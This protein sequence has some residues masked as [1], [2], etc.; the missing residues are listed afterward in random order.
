MRGDEDS[1][2]P[3]AL[4]LG[5]AVVNLV[6]CFL[7]RDQFTVPY[8][9]AAGLTLVYAGIGVWIWSAA[10]LRTA[11]SGLV[12]P[13]GDRL[14]TSGPYRF[15]RHPVYLG[16]TVAM[17]GVG[18]ATASGFGLAVTLLAF[19]PVELYRARLEDRALRRRFGDAW[20]AYARVVPAFLPWRRR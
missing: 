13:P 3:A 17:F 19:L 18:I 6:A 20:S 8:P 7:F 15:V 11:I 1:A 9:K 10:H 12:A 16:T 4:T 2:L 5:V 14:I